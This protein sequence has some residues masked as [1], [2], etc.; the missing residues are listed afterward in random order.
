MLWLLRYERKDIEETDWHGQPGRI[1]TPV[2]Q[3]ARQAGIAVERLIAEH[4][5]TITKLTITPEDPAQPKP[6]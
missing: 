3:N 4:G 2:P 6:K 1:Y 5:A